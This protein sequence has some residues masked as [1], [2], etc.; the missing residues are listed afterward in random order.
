M[1]TINSGMPMP[2][3]ETSEARRCGRRDE[4]DAT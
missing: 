2:N 4:S 1:I 3:I